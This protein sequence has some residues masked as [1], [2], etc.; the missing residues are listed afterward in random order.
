MA[1]FARR[2]GSIC[3]E[4]SVHRILKSFLRDTSGATA[5]EYGVIV[6]VMGLGLVTALS[7]FPTALNSIFST[8]ADNF[9]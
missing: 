1:S 9:K 5:I 7:A 2:S 6:A 8:V 4:L 3:G